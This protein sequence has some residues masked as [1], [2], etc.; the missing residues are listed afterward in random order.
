MGSDTRGPAPGKQEES[1]LDQ[2]V[3]CLRSAESKTPPGLQPWAALS[4]EPQKLRRCVFAEACMLLSGALEAKAI[5]MD[6]LGP[7]ALTLHLTKL[8]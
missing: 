2:A 7:P 1:L 6:H 8:F 4:G 3:S 5:S